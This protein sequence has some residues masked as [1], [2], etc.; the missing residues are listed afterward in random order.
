MKKP[1]G[2]ARE[3]TIE[4]VLAHIEYDQ[5]GGCWLWSGPLSGSGSGRYPA[6]SSHGRD[7]RVHRWMLERQLG[8]ALPTNLRACHKCNVKECVNP[9]HLYA[10]TDADNMRDLRA[11]GRLRERLPVRAKLTVAQVIRLY[12]AEQATARVLATEMGVKE[13]TVSDIRAGR[14][15]TKYTSSLGPPPEKPLR[16]HNHRW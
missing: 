4:R 8:R 9:A 13:G 11:T 16:R 2:N 5:N 10:G 15:W 3:L 6:L 14:A 1:H 12:T 7:V